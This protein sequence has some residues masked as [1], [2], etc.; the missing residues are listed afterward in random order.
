MRVQGEILSAENDVI[1]IRVKADAQ[2][3]VYDH[4]AKTV[5]VRIDDGRSITNDQRR[6]IYACM[7]DIAQLCGYK[8][9]LYF[10]KHFKATYGTAPSKL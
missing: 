1:T 7:K 6:K 5:E 10:S 4:N 9:P 3:W 8:D 2:N